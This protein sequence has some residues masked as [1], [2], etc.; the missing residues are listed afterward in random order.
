MTLSKRASAL[1]TRPLAAGA[2]VALSVALPAAAAHASAVPGAGAESGA[3]KTTYCM[4]VID[5]LK[6]GQSASRVE[7]RSCADSPTASAVRVPAEDVALATF[8]ENEDFDEGGYYTTVV[9]HDGTCDKSGYGLT[10]MTGVE[11]AVNGITSY[12]VWGNCTASRLYT[13]TYYGG[14]QS[15]V[16]YGDVANVGQV[17]NDN[18]YSMKLWNG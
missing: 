18:F 3:K 8:F 17:F 9:G 13:D 10:D 11:L 7:S 12:Y 16:F 2:A 6:P 1:L 4:V 14:T 15:P 5:K